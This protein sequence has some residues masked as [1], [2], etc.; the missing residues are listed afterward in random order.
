MGS[1]VRFAVDTPSRRRRHQPSVQRHEKKNGNCWREKKTARTRGGTEKGRG[2]AVRHVV[3]ATFRFIAA[4]A[5][6]QGM[7]R[8]NTARLLFLLSLWPL[9]EKSEQYRD[10][11][12]AHL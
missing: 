4:S 6:G 8:A 5:W 2:S 3:V 11:E 7:G 9:Q 1:H 12:L 10:R